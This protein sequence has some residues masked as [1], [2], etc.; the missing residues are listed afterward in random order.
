MAVGIPHGCYYGCYYYSACCYSLFD[1]TFP[2]YYDCYHYYYFCYRNP[3]CPCS[4]IGRSSD[5]FFSSTLRVRALPTTVSYTH[6]DV[7]KRQKL[8]L[9]V[10]SLGPNFCFQV[11]ILVLCLFSF[12]LLNF[13]SSFGIHCRMFHFLLSIHL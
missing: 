12:L 8:G 4:C 6:L 11:L 9:F 10:M 1:G 7:Y 3:E 2:Y 13:D 5:G